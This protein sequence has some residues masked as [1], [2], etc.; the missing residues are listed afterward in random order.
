MPPRLAMPTPN[1]VVR[2]DRDPEGRRSVWSVEVLEGK[3][4]RCVHSTVVKM[5]PD[6]RAVATIEVEVDVVDLV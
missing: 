3:E 5:L 6:G 1:V 4:L 2:R